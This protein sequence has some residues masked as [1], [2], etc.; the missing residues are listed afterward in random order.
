MKK[1][2]MTTIQLDGIDTKD[3]PKFCDAYIS[4]ASWDNGEELTESELEE[5][6][7]EN[8]E[9]IHQLVFDFLF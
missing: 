2:D 9:L 7:D 8:G 4:S 3:Y 5:F 6:N 1:I